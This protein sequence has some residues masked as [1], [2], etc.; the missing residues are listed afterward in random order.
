MSD[1]ELLRLFSLSGE[2]AHITVREEEKLELSKLAGKVPIPVKESP[3]EPAAKINILLQAYISRLKLDG[4]ALVAD[5]AFIQQSAARIMRCLFEIALRRKWASLAKLT[6]AM[7]NMVSH[8]IWRSQSPLRQFKNVPEVVSRKLERK[9]DIEWSRYPDLNSSDL[10]ELVG[11][12]KMGRVLHKLVH[13]FPRLELSAS[14][15]QPITRSL[16]RVEL[17]LV[18]AFQFDVDVHG[19]VQLFHVIVEDVN[20]ENILHHEVFSLKSRGD[21]EAFLFPWRK[22]AT[23]WLCGRLWLFYGGRAR[24]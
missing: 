3:N 23:F 6:L 18:P 9:S 2:F 5:M 14:Q 17:L 16:L 24:F 12:P 20:C 22:T 4:F 7:S 10:G 21:E 1:I 8:R 19:Y 11:V 13:Q 15:I